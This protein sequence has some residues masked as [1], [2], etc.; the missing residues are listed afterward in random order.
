MKSNEG[1]TTAN[2]LQMRGIQ[3]TYGQ[4][5]TFK[6]GFGIVIAGED[7]DG[8][9]LDEGSLEMDLRDYIKSGKLTPEAV[10]IIERELNKEN[11][12]IA[13]LRNYWKRASAKVGK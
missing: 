7:T 13:K 4:R 10:G 1:K 5:Y 9:R 6:A 12:D 8:D 2:I 11:P 3:S